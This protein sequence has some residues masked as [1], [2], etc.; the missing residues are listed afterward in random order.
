MRV[1][2]V[3]GWRCEPLAAR[4]ARPILAARDGGGG[5]RW[6]AVAVLPCRPDA[7]TRPHGRGSVTMTLAGAE[8]RLAALRAGRR[9][10]RALRLAARGF[11]APVAWRCRRAGE[12]ATA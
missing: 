5:W 4:L 9:Q 7:D 12:P 10:Y 3:R 8:N 11:G 2:P 6:L 1:Q